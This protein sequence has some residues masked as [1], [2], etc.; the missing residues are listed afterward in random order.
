MCVAAPTVATVLGAILSACMNCE[1]LMSRTGHALNKYLGW[2]S[3]EG[4][5]LKT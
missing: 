3:E 5:A 4:H 1:S 2:R